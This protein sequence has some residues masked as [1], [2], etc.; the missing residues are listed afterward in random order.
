MLPLNCCSHPLSLAIF[1]QLRWRDDAHCSLYFLST[2]VIWA[3]SARG[4]EDPAHCRGL[5]QLNH[6][7]CH[8]SPQGIGRNSPVAPSLP[9]PAMANNNNKL[10]FAFHFSS[11]HTR[12]VA[13]TTYDKFTPSTLRQQ[14]VRSIGL[15]STFVY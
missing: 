8:S 7:N 2:T 15:C 9:F 14:L 5:P 1:G 13:T 12:T 10:Y 11:H 6:H 4:A 3:S